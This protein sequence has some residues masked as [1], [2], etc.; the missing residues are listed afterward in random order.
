MNKKELIEEI[1]LKAGLTKKDAGLAIEAFTDTVIETL[2]KG[3][4]VALLGFGT[5][6]TQPRTGRDGINPST[7]ERIKIPASTSAKFKVGATLKEA[8]K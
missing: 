1:A 4:T 5:F 6:I 7:G 2:V 3:D 8:I